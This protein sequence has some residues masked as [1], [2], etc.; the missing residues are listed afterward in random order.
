MG[1]A[2][3]FTAERMLQIE[4][5]S[6]TGG[7]VDT[8][9]NLLLSTRGGEVIDAGNVK[10]D[11]GE[12]GDPGDPGAPGAAG[13]DVGPAGMVVAFTGTTPPAN[14]L[15]CQG[16][17]VSRVT[18]ASLYAVIGTK[19]GAGNGLTTFN[20]PD[21][22]GR[23]VVGMNAGDS[24]FN[25]L[26]KWGGSKTASHNHALSEVGWARVVAGT[27][28]DGLNTLAIDYVNLGGPTW[29]ADARSSGALNM[30]ASSINP[31]HGAI[32]DGVTNSTTVTTMQPWMVFNYIIKATN[33]D[34]PS[35]SQLTQR[36]SALE[37]LTGSL[38]NTGWVNVAY[39]AGYTLGTGEQ[40]QYRVH[41]NVVYW[42]GGASGTYA[43]GVYQT[44][45]A[46]NAIPTYIL[47][48]MPALRGGAMGT[49][50]R[51]CGFEINTGDKTLKF[52]SNGLATQP[53]WIA[54]TC[55]YPLP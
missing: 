35:D 18:Y 20:L 32:L 36:V 51:P 26:G 19:Y 29:T 9:G 44:V 45:T 55:A 7:L 53:S 27:N 48:D 1:V 30:I 24:D 21:L 5:S 2:T 3:G 15:L 41:K 33:G 42:R 17:E 14:W 31:A 46:A 38:T 22:R 8:N 11:P 10:G 12:P 39:A 28:V 50:M 13:A 6:V 25:V 4:E 23:V 37:S 52:G 49:A 34:T 43:A 16:Q 40:L 47:P 54:F